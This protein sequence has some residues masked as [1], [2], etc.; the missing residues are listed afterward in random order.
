[1]M[2][3]QVTIGHNTTLHG[4]IVE[5]L[6]LIGMGAILATAAADVALNRARSAVWGGFDGIPGDQAYRSD[7]E[8]LR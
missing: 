6:V 1:M 8:L 2:G 4:C 7:G 5:D 3:S